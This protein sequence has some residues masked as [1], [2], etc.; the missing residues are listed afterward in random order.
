MAIT[1]CTNEISADH[2]VTDIATNKIREWICQAGHGSPTTGDLSGN[3]VKSASRKEEEKRRVDVRNWCAEKEAC[4]MV[5][6]LWACKIL[7]QLGSR[8]AWVGS[9]HLSP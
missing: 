1:I 8:M 5:W 2:R 7:W 9:I 3:L 4:R 6:P